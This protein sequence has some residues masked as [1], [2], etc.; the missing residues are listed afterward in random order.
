MGK[1]SDE[2]FSK[3]LE[4]AERRSGLE[5]KDEKAS[6]AEGDEKSLPALALRAGTEMIS[7]L[8]VGVAVG[9]GLDHWFHTRAI[10]LII[11]AL[12]GGS[13]GV[14]NVWRLVKPPQI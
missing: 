3:R 14:L 7:A 8:V 11:F 6:A 12:L 4:A 9:W 1:E 5:K 10:F 13:A 2:S